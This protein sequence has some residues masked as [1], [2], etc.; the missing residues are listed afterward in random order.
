MGV[1]GKQDTR[2]AFRHLSQVALLG[3]PMGHTWL[4]WN[5]MIVSVGVMAMN[6][7]IAEGCGLWLVVCNCTLS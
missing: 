3:F 4:P 7:L 1:S 2:H 6:Y 5:V